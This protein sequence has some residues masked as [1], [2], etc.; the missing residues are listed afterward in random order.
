LTIVAIIGKKTEKKRER[1]K[2]DKERRR[3][4]EEE[5]NEIDFSSNVFL[6]SHIVLS[7]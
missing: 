7:N 6:P 1:E 5:R 3:R 4:R 2:N